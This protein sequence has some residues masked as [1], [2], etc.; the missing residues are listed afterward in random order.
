MKIAKDFTE[1]DF[2]MPVANRY[3]STKNGKKDNLYLVDYIPNL[4]EKLKHCAAY[5]TYGGYNA[6]TEILKGQI[7]SI[8][9]PRES[10]RKMEQFVRAYVFEPYNFFKVLNN[11]EFYKLS[12]VLTE[13]L[14]KKPNK[15]N[16]KINGAE[17]SARVI[18]KIHNG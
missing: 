14:T 17:E 1:Y 9:I 10:G 15:F 12:E 4:R 2:I 16:F 18:T 6:T 3:M 7:P 8:I 11:S 13:V 5:I